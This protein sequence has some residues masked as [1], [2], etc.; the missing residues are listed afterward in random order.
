MRNHN[1]CKTPQTVISKSSQ[2][3]SST[4]VWSGLWQLKKPVIG[5]V[6]GVFG[7]DSGLGFFGFFGGLCVR[8]LKCYFFVLFCLDWI[9]FHQ[10]DTSSSFRNA[11]ELCLSQC[12]RPRNRED[13]PTGSFSLLSDFLFP[14]R[15]LSKC[16]KMRT[17]L[18]VLN[19]FLIVRELSTS[20]VGQILFFFCFPS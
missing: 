16:G 5:D 12:S 1:V 2:P 9:V 3:S 20:V 17:G 4:F 15:F 13:A 10:N 7:S 8:F 18:G 14:V 19:C 11:P 6:N